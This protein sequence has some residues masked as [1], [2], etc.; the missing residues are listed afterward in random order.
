MSPPEPHKQSSN[1]TGR[2]R[3]D[4]K[5]IDYIKYRNTYNRIKR[6]TKRTYYFDLFK[7]YKNDIRNTWKILKSIIGR[8]N[9]NTSISEQFK[10]EN[11]VTTDPPI[12][13]NE[14]CKYL[15]SVGNTFAS[16]IPPPIQKFYYYLPNQKSMTQ[17]I[18]F[19][20]PI[21]LKYCVPS[22]PSRLNKVLVLI[23]L[24]LISSKTINHL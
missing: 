22:T 6:M 8:E 16:A 14:F 2:H 17:S 7:K 21:Q 23:T 13:S 3:Q 12:I 19:S 15:S 18:Y 20:P 4:Q 5:H 9:D 10:C 1:V 11:I 24:V